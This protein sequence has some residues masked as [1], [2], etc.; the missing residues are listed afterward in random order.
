MRTKTLWNN[1]WYFY[2]DTACGETLPAEPLPWQPV[3]LPHD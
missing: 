2:A 3:T 1:G